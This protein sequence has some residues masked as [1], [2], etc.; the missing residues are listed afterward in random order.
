M[1]AETVDLLFSLPFW[2]A[3]LR[4]AT[5]ELRDGHPGGAERAYALASAI[6]KFAPSW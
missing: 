3:V 4:I 5:N 1:L 2:V 6:S